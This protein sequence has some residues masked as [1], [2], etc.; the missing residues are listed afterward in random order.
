MKKP[1]LVCALCMLC[2]SAFA[3]PELPLAPESSSQESITNNT[4]TAPAAASSNGFGIH[5]GLTFLNN[6][7]QANGYSRD[8]DMGTTFGVHYL[9]GDNTSWIRGGFGMFYCLGSE[10]VKGENLSE[11]EPSGN[12]FAARTFYATMQI[13]PFRSLGGNVYIKG[14]LGVKLPSLWGTLLLA[15]MDG[16]GDCPESGVGHW[17]ECQPANS[18]SS[19]RFVGKAAF[20]CAFGAGLDIYKNKYFLEV[21][22]NYY[23]FERESI[24]QGF[25]LFKSESNGQ[26]YSRMRYDFLAINAGV[27]F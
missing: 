1:L 13:Y 26:R 8:Y 9:F 14:N 17:D 4:V 10:P 7:T 24:S 21:M 27:R 23:G 3:L 15:M 19:P 12:G 22:Y 16:G 18:W 25:H 20:Y 2:V 11:P 5:F 6:Q